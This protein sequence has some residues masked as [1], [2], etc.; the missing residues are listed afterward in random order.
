MTQVPTG[1]YGQVTYDDQKQAYVLIDNNAT[2]PIENSMYAIYHNHT[3]RS[4]QYD[5]KTKQFQQISVHECELTTRHLLCQDN[6][7]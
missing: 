3:K 6:L 2:V 1:F 4:F 7:S 5:H